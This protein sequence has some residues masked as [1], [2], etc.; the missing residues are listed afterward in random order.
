MGAIVGKP[1]SGGSVGVAGAGA[2]GMASGVEVALAVVAVVVAA[3]D[4]GAVV[5]GVAGVPR[6]Q[7]PASSVRAHATRASTAVDVEPVGL[8]MV[9]VL[10]PA[11]PSRRDRRLTEAAAGGNAVAA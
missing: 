11:R 10:M 7:P 6:A 3:G 2:A 8:H 1:V 4:V 9:N 5:D